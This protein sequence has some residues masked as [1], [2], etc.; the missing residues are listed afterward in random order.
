MSRT[1]FG[2]REYRRRMNEREDKGESLWTE[3]LDDAARIKLVHVINRFM[4][5][6]HLRYDLEEQLPK[7]IQ[8]INYQIGI[9]S[10]SSAFN[11]RAKSTHEEVV[12][13]ILNDGC[14]EEIIF[15]LL[16]AF[17]DIVPHYPTSFSAS[18][19]DIYANSI[20][21]IL[22]DHRVSYDFVE[23]NIIPRGE[24]EMHVEVVV[25]AITL[26]SGR[27]DFEDVERNYME[28]LTSIRE[29]R[30]D[31]AVTNAASAVEATLRILDCGDTQ[32]PLAKR[33][34]MAIERNLLAPHDRGL[35]GWITA[36][37]GSEGD[38]HG[39]GSHTARADAWLVV[40]V[41]GALILRLVDGPNRGLGS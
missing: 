8:I 22:E 15:S 5:D 30:F 36:T 14:K 28:A 10:L 35:L 23:G 41:A 3:S 2:L 33:G 6:D 4:N 24:Q 39:Q 34:A 13:A 21:S 1:Y 9:M 19:R 29:Q 32:T 31:D 18:P 26:L 27:S 20:R 37:R 16:E 25:P 40:H 12:G 11:F 7:I 17:W 38:A